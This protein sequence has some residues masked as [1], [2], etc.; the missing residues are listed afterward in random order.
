MASVGQ[1]YLQKGNRAIARKWAARSLSEAKCAASYD[2]LANILNEEGEQN[3]ALAAYGQALAISPDSAQILTERGSLLLKLN[4][5]QD[6][7]NDFAKA[8]HIEPNDERRYRLA[9]TYAADLTCEPY[10][11]KQHSSMPAREVLNLLGESA[12]DTFF[13][14]NHP[15]TLLLV[16]QACY[17]LDDMDGAYWYVQEYL[18][19][20]PT[21]ATAKQLQQAI[22]QRH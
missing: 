11:S 4:R 9:L 7:R 8:M 13:V 21:S 17:E 12:S 19:A 1:Q 20:N 2:L 5:N 15:L 18:E 3:E 22:S 6:A 16:A 10:G 14:M